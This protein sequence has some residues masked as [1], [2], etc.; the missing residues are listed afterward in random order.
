LPRHDVVLAEGLPV[1]S[2][3]DEG[4]KSNFSQ[5]AD[6]MRLFPDFGKLHQEPEVRRESHGC[7]PL[8]VHGPELNAVRLRLSRLARHTPSRLVA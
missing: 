1:E 7:A 2:Y 3:L 6:V 5:A 4:G 8:V